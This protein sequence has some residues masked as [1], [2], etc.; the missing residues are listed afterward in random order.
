MPKRSLTVTSKD[1]QTMTADI[2]LELEYSDAEWGAFQ[3]AVQDG[4]DSRAFI[5]SLS[6]DNW[7]VKPNPLYRVT[8]GPMN[9]QQEYSIP[10]LDSEAGKRVFSLDGICLILH[11]A[12]KVQ[13]H[14][15]SA[16]VVPAGDTLES[17]VNASKSG[18]SAGLSKK[19][20]DVPFVE[21]ENERKKSSPK[22]LGEKTLGVQFSLPDGVF[23]KL[24]EAQELAN[25]QSG[26]AVRSPSGRN[27]AVSTDSSSSNLADNA[28][29][30]PGKKTQNNGIMGACFACFEG[31]FTKN[32][33]KEQKL[34]ELAGESF[35]VTTIKD[36]VNVGNKEDDGAGVVV[37]AE[38][39]NSKRD[40][41]PR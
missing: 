3:S 36:L 24:R 32:K 18:A 40:G 16:G 4:I 28:A 7:I 33:S 15:Y 13:Q 27:S 6:G 9:I 23:L 31:M 8:L 25:T 10:A 2:N 26:F 34:K 17:A 35:A 41:R 5:M 29:A 11:N 38:E 20:V 22:H 1:G 14:A 21:I 37:V 19:L 30:A 12:G 39:K